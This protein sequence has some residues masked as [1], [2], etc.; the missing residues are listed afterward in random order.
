[1]SHYYIG[2]EGMQVSRNLTEKAGRNGVQRRLLGFFINID[3]PM[4]HTKTHN[5]TCAYD[6]LD[7]QL[8]IQMQRQ[9]GLML[10]V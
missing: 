7:I 3:N 9:M 8:Q 4:Q 2:E 10:R 1:M 5:P 6:M